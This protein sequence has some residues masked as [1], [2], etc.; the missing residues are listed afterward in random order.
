NFTGR[1]NR[2]EQRT[3]RPN[4]VGTRRCS[5]RFR[6]PGSL[7]QGQSGRS[8]PEGGQPVYRSIPVYRGAGGKRRP[9]AGRDDARGDGCLVGGS[10]TE[11]S[12]SPDRIRLRTVNEECQ[13]TPWTLNRTT[14]RKASEPVSSPAS[15]F[16]A[17]SRGCGCL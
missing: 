10:K 7:H 3:P 9:N 2:G 4:R 15:S 1:N 6:Q 17:R 14:T 13:E 16:S 11:A 5:V 8:A 12:S